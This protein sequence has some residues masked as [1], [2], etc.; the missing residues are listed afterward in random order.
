MEGFGLTRADRSLLTPHSMDFS[1]WLAR[2]SR[3]KLAASVSSRQ[4]RR[5]ANLCQL[6][7]DDEI[8]L[9]FTHLQISLI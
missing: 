4:R 6:D 7:F 3:G 5:T 2:R 1:M 8:N 9:N